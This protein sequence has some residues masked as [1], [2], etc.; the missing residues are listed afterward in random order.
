[1]SFP[2]SLPDCKKVTLETSDDMEPL[3]GFVDC[4]A[5]K[6]SD[7][8]EDINLQD[9]FKV[10]LVLVNGNSSSPDE[11]LQSVEEVSKA[12]AE[13]P[14][15]FAFKSI[16]QGKRLSSLCDMA[17][18][19]RGHI[20]AICKKLEKV[21]EECT[22]FESTIASLSSE[23][24]MKNIASVMSSY[25]AALPT[26]KD[27]GDDEAVKRQVTLTK[28]SILRLLKH[29]LKSYC[30]TEFVSWVGTQA[31]TLSA[32]KI[33]TK[34][35]ACSLINLKQALACSTFGEEGVVVIK[36]LTDLET[37]YTTCAELSKDTEAILRTPPDEK[38]KQRE[39]T[40]CLCRNFKAW[41]EATVKL[42]CSV[43][44]VSCA[45]DAFS[46]C[47]H[48]LV[49]AACSQVW[50]SC[51]AVPLKILSTLMQ[52]GELQMSEEDVKKLLATAK[53]AVA[54]AM[55][56]GTGLEAGS[57]NLHQAAEF[58][59]FIVDYAEA[60]CSYS[61]ESSDSA[62]SAAYTLFRMFKHFKL[63]I[64][65]HLTDE[66]LEISKDVIQFLALFKNIPTAQSNTV[67]H[68]FSA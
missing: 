15:L 65:E 30:E 34:P 38:A 45:T 12:S 24:T 41:K 35:P 27:K 28:S 40:V 8:T 13:D 29:T 57:A 20:Q 2:L 19:S 52:S 62:T 49:A 3:R 53:T 37:F 25:K 17:C 47:M 58:L 46:S 59:S 14:I 23:E 44:S 48:G 4:M 60:Q 39:A 67:M 16:P 43:P 1:M 32:S 66:R 10:V 54:D 7:S 5:Q 63:T 11:L 22:V 55:L 61:G 50:K 64:H 26:F 33:M 42:H 6:Y 9:E 56:L 31:K 21:V 51:M 36:S 68:P 18:Q